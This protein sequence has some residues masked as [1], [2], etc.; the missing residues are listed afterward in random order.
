MFDNGLEYIRADF[1]LHTKKDKEFKYKGEENDFV[2][3]YI[4][5]LK[6]A[7]IRIGV[8]TNHNKFDKGEYADLKKKA[9][10]EEILILP[11]V[12]LSVKE[13]SNGI[14]TLI[15]FDPDKWL[16]NGDN[17]I[18]SFLTTAFAGISNPENR[19]TRCRFD[20][21]EMFKSLD[22]YGRDYFV[23]FAHVNQK[24]G[25]FEECGG[26]LLQSLAEVVSFRERV[27]GLQK[28]RT[29]SKLSLFKDCFGYLPA[30]V[31]GSDPKSID[32]IGK[33]D[34]F[35]YLKV[36]E[37][38]YSAVKFALQDYQKRVTDQKPSTNHGYI[39]AISFEG[40]KFSGQDIHFS[41]SLNTLIGIRGSGKSAILES[42]RYV[43]DIEIQAEKDYKNSLIDS[44]LGSGGKITLSIVDKHGHKY[45]VSRILNQHTIILDENGNK[46]DISPLSLFDGIQYFGQNDMSASVDH[47]NKL[48][49]KF[50]GDNIAASN[51]KDVEDKIIRFFEKLLEMN[52]IPDRISE[53]QSKMSDI[54]HKLSI[55]AE[56][57]VEEKLKKQ[58]D[59]TADKSKIDF[60]KSEMERIG[61]AI[62]KFC[63]TYPEIKTDLDGYQS[64]YNNEL[65]SQLKTVIENANH[66]LKNINNSKKEF[67]SLIKQIECFSTEIEQ[68]EED[69]SDE[70]AAIK[71][72][73]KDETIDADVF[74]RL[75][76]NKIDTEN[77]LNK[78]SEQLKNED[79][80][81][82]DFSLL[83]KQRND[84]LKKA[85]NQY[86]DFTEK[87]NLSQS[88]IKIEIVFKGDRQSFKTKM[89][90]DFKGTGISDSKYSNIS[91]CFSDYVDILEDWI[92]N[93]GQKLKGILGRTEFEK[94][95][96]KIVEQYKDLLLFQVPDKVEIKYHDILLRNHSLGQR[97]SALILFLLTQNNNEIIIIDQPEDD[98]DNK[99]IYDEVITTISETKQNVQFIFAT[100]NANIP[101]LGDA[102][103][104]LVVKFKESSIEVSQGNIDNSETQS[105]IVDIMEGG[106]EA[107]SRRKMIYT[108]WNVKPK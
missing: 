21:R 74:L 4:Q 62:N 39:E 27:L 15:V 58:K 40:G 1:H 107:F 98:L 67:F 18:Q 59:F 87:I 66:E 54:N 48:L 28:F 32:E 13:G 50:A 37:R 81:K 16:E 71:R 53:L 5:G 51:L 42:I 6:K 92:I 26:G 24:S 103:R 63:D 65:L 90:T 45:L 85:F 88:E 55:Y 43:L 38:S 97:A 96:Q 72:E 105:Q 89:K 33:G 41:P 94:F 102:E 9:K 35:T 93:D 11:G 100:H 19:N 95:S 12:E 29:Y 75:Q 79:Q 70:F 77:E 64:D 56:K 25:F 91:S 108:S 60:Y 106:K 80:M 20:L 49:D 34:R 69:L 14:H 83:I 17:H 47:E 30:L 76:K 10:K 86:K 61:E 82:S 22:E 36:G 52:D 44:I 2:K 99:V 23:I 84:E 46:K 101:V 8:I 104:V 31:E 57:G 68:K 78:L 3:S 7:G 73:I